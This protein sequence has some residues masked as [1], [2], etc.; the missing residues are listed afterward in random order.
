MDEKVYAL[1]IELESLCASSATPVIRSP[2]DV[3][4]I[5]ISQYGS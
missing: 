5:L 3:F 4:G 2:S 1:I